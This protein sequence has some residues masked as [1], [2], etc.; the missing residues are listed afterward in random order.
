M[1]EIRK[2]AIL[3]IAT[4]KASEYTTLEEKQT[5][6]EQRIQDEITRL[7]SL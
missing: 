6:L 2:Q 1:D 7:E 4:P 3:N 5:L